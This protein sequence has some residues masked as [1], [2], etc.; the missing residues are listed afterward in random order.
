MT[1][2]NESQVQFSYTLPD[3][4]TQT[5]TRTSNI[6]KTEVISYSFNK[7]KS[8][9]KSFLQ[10]GETATQ[11]VLL[12]NN[13]L[14]NI[15]NLFFND[16]MSA[17][18]THVAG[19]VTVN[20]VPQP[21]YDVQTGFALDDLAPNGVATVTYDV[22]ADSPLTVTPVQN[23]G[24]VNYSVGSSNFNENTNT[25]NL[26]V[27][28]NRLTIIKTVDKS[29]AVIGDNLHYVSTITN[30]GTLL[31]T[32]LTFTDPIPSGTSFVAGSVKIDGVSQPGY[33]PSVGFPLA[34]LAVGATTVVE[35]D[36]TVL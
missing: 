3:G 17:G 19:S 6:V 24:T 7:V 27:V 31:K 34:N 26:I 18:A 12:T 20:G 32:N 16:T 11:T 5:E 21:S 33:D 23:Y 25:I 4:T 14:F 28:S 30:T 1:I 22:I 35:F 36:V 15:S 10:E 2:S 8:S 29:V 13:S 9:N